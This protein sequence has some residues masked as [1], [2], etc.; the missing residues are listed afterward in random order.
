MCIHIHVW[1]SL[2]AQWL[3]SLTA[4]Q[5][6]R[7]QALGWEDPLEKKI[8]THSSTLAWKIP[9]TE[10]PG[11]PT[12]FWGVAKSRT[13]LSDFTFTF[14]SYLM[15]G[16]LNEWGQ[17]KYHLILETSPH[18]C[19][20]RATSSSFS[21]K[22]RLRLERVSSLS[23]QFLEPASHAIGPSATAATTIHS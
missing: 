11:R 23:S 21:W 10:K 3:K 1:A 13:R 15:N 20:Q 9:W 19:S 5:E 7:V 18:L 8:A 16:L 17:L 6:T 22:D 12:V 2:V 14:K 4:M